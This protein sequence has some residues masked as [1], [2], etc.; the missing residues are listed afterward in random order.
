MYLW[1]DPPAHWCV[2][3]WSEPPAYQTRLQFYFFGQCSLWGQVI[4]T[5]VRKCGG[6]ASAMDTKTL[7]SPIWVTWGCVMDLLCYAGGAGCLKLLYFKLLSKKVCPGMDVPYRQIQ[8]SKVGSLIEYIVYILASIFYILLAIK[9]F[10][11]F[12][13]YLICQLSSIYLF[14]TTKPTVLGAHS[15]Q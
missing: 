12:Q 8:S 5:W 14:K 7:Q 3:C 9:L 6:A 13:V 4:C 10:V 11:S 2:Y 15:S 1:W